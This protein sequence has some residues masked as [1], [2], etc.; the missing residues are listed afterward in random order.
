MEVVPHDFVVC[1]FSVRPNI[2]TIAASVNPINHNSTVTFTG[3]FS[4]AL[5]ATVKWQKSNGN[6]FIDI[7]TS[8]DKYAGSST[9]GENTNLV[10]N[11]VMFTDEVTYRLMVSNGVGPTTSNGVLLDV[12]GGMFITI[13]NLIHCSIKKELCSLYTVASRLL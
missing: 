6:G 12:I 7:D 3:S 13:I 2:S 5:K 1:I 8:E 9:V 10:I 11:S 4:S